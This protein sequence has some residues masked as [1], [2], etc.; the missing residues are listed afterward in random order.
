MD[1]PVRPTDT[2]RTLARMASKSD[3]SISPASGAAARRDNSASSLAS[4]A[5]SCSTKLRTYASTD[6]NPL[7]AAR[8]SASNL[9]RSDSSMVKVAIISILS[10]CD[11]DEKIYQFY[12]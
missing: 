5:V 11:P 4:A 10:S 2:E 9:P 6:S 7:S 8:R 3:V 1:H 12:I